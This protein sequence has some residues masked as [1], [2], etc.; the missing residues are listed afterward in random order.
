MTEEARI[1][2]VIHQLLKQKSR[3]VIAPSETL[4]AWI[5]QFAKFGSRMRSVRAL[6]ALG[7]RA[8]APQAL[9]NAFYVLQDQSAVHADCTC[10]TCAVH[11]NAAADV[12][13]NGGKPEYKWTD[14]HA[15]EMRR[16]LSKDSLQ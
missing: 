3:G 8:R 10:C 14:L 12:T 16:L 15:E 9:G 4:A 13:E 7:A 2:G 6:G 11:G 1:A 5:R